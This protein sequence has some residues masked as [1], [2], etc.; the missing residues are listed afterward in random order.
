M[1]LPRPDKNQSQKEFVNKCMDDTAM[2]NEFPNNKQRAAVCYS[3]YERATKS[4]AS[5]WDDYMNGY[6]PYDLIIF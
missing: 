4:K 1:P 5:T 6:H 2:L 3:Q